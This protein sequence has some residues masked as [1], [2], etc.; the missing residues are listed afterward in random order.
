ML[1]LEGLDVKDPPLISEM[2]V[3]ATSLTPKPS[4]YLRSLGCRGMPEVGI[5]FSAHSPLCPGFIERGF[6]RRRPEAGD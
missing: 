4:G 6:E 5:E 1:F 2:L 3:N